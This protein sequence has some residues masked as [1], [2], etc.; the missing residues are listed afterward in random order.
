MHGCPV[1]RV[2]DCRV[3]T[4]KRL[5][6]QG[7]ASFDS[8]QV[9]GEIL[10]PVRRTV[11]KIERGERKGGG[12]NG[13]FAFALHVQAPKSRA[14]A[15]GSESKGRGLQTPDYLVSSLESNIE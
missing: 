5:A 15:I 9:C 10:K 4:L 12:D 6:F 14:G 2:P 13:T 3:L 7:Y 8:R 11:S 1:C